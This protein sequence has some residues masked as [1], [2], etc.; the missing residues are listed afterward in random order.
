MWN[1]K[2]HNEDEASGALLIPFHRIPIRSS[3]TRME[4]IVSNHQELRDHLVRRLARLSKRA[5]KIAAHLRKP[6]NADWQERAV[7]IENDEVLEGLDTSTQDEVRRLQD[8][9][10]RID[11]GVYGI[12]TGC[13]K[14]IA[15]A[16]LEAVPDAALCI[17]CADAE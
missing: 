17:Q 11:A 16:R 6:G 1:Q 13:E 9:L 3:A 2:L 4:H 8:A 7:E 14:P 12:C 5:G 10:K 15:E